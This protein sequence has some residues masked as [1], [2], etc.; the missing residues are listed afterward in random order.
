MKKFLQ[1]CYLFASTVFGQE[2]EKS[3]YQFPI[4][5]GEQNFLAGTVGEIRTSHFHTGIDV[6]TF[7]KVGLPIYA[8]ADGFVFRVK[9]SAYGYGNALYLQHPNNTFTV[10]AHLESFNEEIDEYVVEEQYNQQSFEVNLFPRQGRLSVKKGEIIGYSGNSGSSSGPHLHFEIRNASQQPIDVLSLD[11]NEV[12]DGRAPIASKIAFVTLEENARI[13]GLFGRFEY[14]LVKYQNEIMLAQSVSLSGKIG[15]EVYAYDPMDGIA[16]KNGIQSTIMKVNEKKIFEERKEK[17][18]FNQQRNILQHYD[19][20]SYKQ[21]NKKFN[22]LYLAD[23]N[24]HDMYTVTNK[25]YLFSKD[26]KVEIILV[27]SYANKTTVTFVNSS[28]SKDPV[29]TAINPAEQGNFL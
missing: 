12:K 18:S 8:A 17:F 24:F 9:V 26:E 22:R 13:N 10:Y 11:F 5:P 6:K 25:G 15:I 23:G 14:D 20:S 4:R 19:Y 3:Y 29:L 16:N 2:I 27:D 7:G 28:P 21:G 1:L